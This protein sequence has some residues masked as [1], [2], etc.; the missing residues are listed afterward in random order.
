MEA[1]LFKQWED[2]FLPIP[3]KCSLDP[4]EH[5][6]KWAGLR[7]PDLVNLASLSSAFTFI[8]VGFSVAFLV[9]LIEYCM[10]KT[11]PPNL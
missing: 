8:L 6:D 3:R 4:F 1:G 2:R 7:H 10:S 5:K 9:F 11:F